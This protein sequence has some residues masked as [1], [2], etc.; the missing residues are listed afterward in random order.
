MNQGLH[1]AEDAQELSAVAVGFFLKV[2]QDSRDY[3][4]KNKIGIGSNKNGEV[5]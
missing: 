3:Y 1:I 4:I 5:W 2:K